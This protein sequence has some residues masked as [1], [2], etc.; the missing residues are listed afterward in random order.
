MEQRINIKFCVKLQKTAT[1]TLAMLKMAYGEDNCMSRNRVFQW[2]RRFSEGREDVHDDPRSG[3]PTTESTDDNVARVRQVVRQDRRL[4]IRMIALELDM[5][6]EVVRKILTETLNMRK[7]SA[8]IVPRILT[9]EQKQARM[10]TCNDFL[11]QTGNDVDFLGSI[12]TGDETWCYEYDPETKRQSMTWKTAGSPKPKKA[13]MSKSNI[14]TMM[15]C[16][17]DMAGVVH[18]EFVPP[19]QTVNGPFYI[20]VL[21]RLRDAVRRKRPEKW[22]NS[23]ILHHDNAPTHSSFV[24]RQYLAK[25]NIPTLQHPP[26]SPDLAPNDFWLFPR[27]KTKLKGT[28]FQSIEEIQQNATRELE[29]ISKLGFQSCFEQ[30]QRRARH[31]IESQGDYFEGDK[32]Q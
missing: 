3:R 23:W 30:W 14:K 4:T 1:E 17:F 9:A 13:R 8:K 21:G 16:F 20:A 15:I 7:V 32:H 6:R 11:A 2:H 27:L 5:N 12:I 18:K 31:C 25:H 22:P 19:G 26:Y 24:V 29:S 28:R 10:D